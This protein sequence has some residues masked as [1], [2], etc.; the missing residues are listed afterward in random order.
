MFCTLQVKLACAKN[1]CFAKIEH[2]MSELC[3]LWYILLQLIN[4]CNCCQY[5]ILKLLKFQLSLWSACLLINLCMQLW[6]LDG[7]ESMAFI[8]NVV[9]LVTYFFG[10]MNFNCTM[11][12]QCYLLLQQVFHRL[13]LFLKYVFGC[14]ICKYIVLIKNVTRKNFLNSNIILLQNINLGWIWFHNLNIS[15]VL[16]NTSWC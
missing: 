8:A 3:Q 14:E 4:L 11:W 5:S 7:L 1:G 13:M 2:T 15:F 10:Y 9:S 12:K 16:Q 6:I